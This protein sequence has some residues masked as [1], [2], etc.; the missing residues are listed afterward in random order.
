MQ[1]PSTPV[2]TLLGV[3]EVARRLGISIRTVRGLISRGA[4]AAIRITDRRIAV[5]EVDLA[6][7]VADRRKH[8]R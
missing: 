5:D 3:S 2:P 1:Q 4:L 8:S 7:Y 6:S